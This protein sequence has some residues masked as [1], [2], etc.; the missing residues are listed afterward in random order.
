VLPKLLNYLAFQSY[1]F[2][3]P[4]EGYFRNVHD[5]DIVFLVPDSCRATPRNLQYKRGRLK[6]LERCP[7]LLFLD[8]LAVVFFNY[9]TLDRVKPKIINWYL[10]LIMQSTQN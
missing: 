3:L 2:E 7:F 9:K 5:Q 10:L 8:N 1:D 6:R 4:D